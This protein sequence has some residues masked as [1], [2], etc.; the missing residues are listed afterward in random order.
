MLID[1]S[2]MFTVGDTVNITV[3][4]LFFNGGRQ[5]KIRQVIAAQSGASSGPEIIQSGG[6]ATISSNESSTYDW[7]NRITAVNGSLNITLNWVGGF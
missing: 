3:P 4:A 5:L 1:A 2:E 7:I 6:S